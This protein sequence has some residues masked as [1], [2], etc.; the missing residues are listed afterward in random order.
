MDCKG[1]SQKERSLAV[2]MYRL[3][4]FVP[5]DGSSRLMVVFEWFTFSVIGIALRVR[6]VCVDNV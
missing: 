4:W 2:L 5:V 6:C 3:P 1:T